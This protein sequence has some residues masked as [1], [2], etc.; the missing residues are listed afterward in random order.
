MLRPR[1]IVGYLCS[2]VLIW[3]S[4]VAGYSSFATLSDL[5][6]SPV[7]SMPG[8]S[9]HVSHTHAAHGDSH[10]DILHAPENPL[11]ACIAACVELVTDKVLPRASDGQVDLKSSA[12]VYPGREHSDREIESQLLSYWPT[13]P[14]GLRSSSESGAARLVALNARLRI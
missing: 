2:A 4:V 12:A 14:P 11:A 3:M 6:M 1:A 7:I 5:R 10:H 8:D 13:G 9:H